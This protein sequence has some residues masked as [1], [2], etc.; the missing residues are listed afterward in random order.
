MCLDPAFSANVFTLSN[1]FS[2]CCSSSVHRW[3]VFVSACLSMAID[4]GFIFSSGALF[5]NIMGTYNTNR[6]EAALVQSVLM[7]VRFG[8]GMNFFTLN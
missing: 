4:V 2:H 3:L 8:T 5:V 1:S 6:T 7:S